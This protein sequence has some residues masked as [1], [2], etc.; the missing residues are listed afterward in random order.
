MKYLKQTFENNIWKY[1][2]LQLSQRRNFIPILSIFFLTLPW[3]DATQIWLYTWIWYLF[4]FLFQIPSWYFSDRFWHKYTLIIS[5]FLMIFSSIFFINWG[6]FY[7][8]VFW[9]IF[10]SLS[11]S[12]D[13]WAKSA[14]LHETL[15]K[16]NTVT[17]FTKVKWKIDANISFLS[18]FL[19]VSLPFLTK[20][21][22]VLPIKIWLF[23][24]II[25]L[26]CA[27]LLRSTD[28]HIHSKDQKS[29]IT[30]FRESKNLGFLPVVIFIS[31]I[32]W[33]LTADSAFR[34]VYLESIGYPI[35]LIWFVMWLSRLVRFIVWHFSYLIKDYFT[36]KQQFLF[37][38][39]IFS[40]FYLLISFFDNPYFVWAI[41]SIWVWYQW[42]RQS[43]LEDYILTDYIKDKRYKAT[44][45]SIKWQITAIFQ[46]SMAFFIW[47]IM[48]YSYKIWFLTMWI[49]LFLILVISYSFIKD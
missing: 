19:I 35:V 9:S 25:W 46:F 28:N 41:I 26:I 47:F 37:E 39:I 5:K 12:L 2:V 13:S 38:I 16:L 29:L 43:V 49:L 33:F 21:D 18:I 23:I 34:T 22:L 15:E 1:F 31:A 27:L 14:F 4:S 32:A 8:F 3:T 11:F 45:L 48:N 24:D 42:W 20:I 17:S 7:D 30:V 44:I 36:L 10:L 40:I 6:W